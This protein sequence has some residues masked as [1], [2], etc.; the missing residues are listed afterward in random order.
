MSA[1]FSSPKQP[2]E[3]KIVEDEEVD[4]DERRRRARAF[5]TKG[6]RANILT[7]GGPQSAN[8]E[9]RSLLGG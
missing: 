1:L 2:R 8:V 5:A 7:A 9:R 3:Q 4:E 6:R